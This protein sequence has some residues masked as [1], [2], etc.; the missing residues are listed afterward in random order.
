MSI[1]IPDPFSD[2]TFMNFAEM[3]AEVT[4]LL[5]KGKLRRAEK[6]LNQMLAIDRNYLPAHFHLARV[7]RR[8]GQYEFALRHARRTLSLNPKERNAYLNYGMIFDL[9][10]D[11]KRALFYY[12]KELAGNPF[13][14][15]TLWNRGRL[16]FKKHRWLLA[17][18]DLNRCFKMGF[19]FDLD[20]TVQ[21][22]AFCY[23]KRHDLKLYIDL[24]TR[25][26]QS[27]PNAAWAQANLGYAYLFAK[28]YKRAAIWLSRAA[29]L[30]TK[31]GVLIDLARVRKMLAN[32]SKK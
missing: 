11:S 14:A 7:Y 13:S 18:N 23:Y 5:D 1:F 19:S 28:D 10:G 32:G 6:V 17:S 22:L 8:T 20:D 27:F 15:E 2:L 25:Y 21:K 9:M 16:Y 30:A 12:G 3:E 26:L 29:R 4:N 24:Y 31:R